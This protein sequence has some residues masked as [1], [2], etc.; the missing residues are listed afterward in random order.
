MTTYRSP[1]V[2][3]VSLAAL[4][5]I[6][7]SFSLARS[8]P[9]A[10]SVPRWIWSEADPKGDQTA[11]FRKVIDVPDGVTSARLIATCDN[12]VELLIDGK[13]VLAEQGMGRRR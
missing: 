11:Y 2:W 1:R 3:L 7:G 5:G 10:G 4:A 12:E 9:E 8:A 6:A 13:R